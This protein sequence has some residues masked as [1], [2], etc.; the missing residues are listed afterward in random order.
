MVDVLRSKWK[1]DENK[2]KCY[3]DDDTGKTAFQAKWDD[4]NNQLELQGDADYR[5]KW[6]DSTNKLEAQQVDENECDITVC[7]DN[8]P[9]QLDVFF[10][11][12]VDCVACDVNF[13]NMNG[14]TYRLT[15]IDYIIG[16]EY[17]DV[18]WNI[19][20]LCTG[21]PESKLYLWVRNAALTAQGFF[22]DPA[23]V[24]LPQ[25]VTNSYVIG[26][27]CVG[28]TKAHSGTALVS[29]V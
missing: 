22:D 27:C 10:Q 9:S 11:N 12:I 19:H 21:V 1:D 6:N 29:A 16:W 26:D 17:I 20:I 7:N 2:L 13:E 8:K 23:A 24:D 5:V 3:C 4:T 18:N 25:M 15:Y 14:N 28:G